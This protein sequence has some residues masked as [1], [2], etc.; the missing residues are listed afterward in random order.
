M[1]EVLG[2]IASGLQV[3]ALAGKIIS[4]GLKIRTL[5]H[6]I[7]DASE[8]V[9]LRLQELEALSETLQDSKLVSSK[10]RRFCERCISELY[11][12]LGDL[13]G[14]IQKSRGMKRMVASTKVILKKDTIR[15][16]ESRLDRSVQLLGLATQCLMEAKISLMLDKQDAIKTLFTAYVGQARVIEKS[17]STQP[18]ES[19]CVESRAIDDMR[20]LTRIQASCPKPCVDD[21]KVW[22]FERLSSETPVMSWT[23]GLSSIT[24]IVQLERFLARDTHY[25]STG[26]RDSTGRVA[27]TSRY[28]TRVQLALPHWLSYKVLELVASRAQLG[29]KQYLR[30]RSIFPEAEFS[31]ARGQ[32]AF[33]VA[34]RYV[35][36]GNLDRLT[37]LFESRELTPWDEDTGGETLLSFSVS[38]GRWDVC[39]FLLDVGAEP[40]LDESFK[41]GRLEEDDSL[42]VS[43]LS[44]YIGFFDEFCALRRFAWP[45][46][47]FYHPD[48]AVYRMQFAVYI[49]CALNNGW[50]APALI[51]SVLGLDNGIARDNLNFSVRTISGE[52]IF[53]GLA[54][55]IGLANARG[56]AGEWHRLIRDVVA[57]VVDDRDLHQYGPSVTLGFEEFPKVLEETTPLLSLILQGILAE[58]RH[59]RWPLRTRVPERPT[60]QPAVVLLGCEKL[61]FAWL[62]DFYEAGVDLLEYGRKEK[63]HFRDEEF[64]P[65]GPT[66]SYFSDLGR[67][68]EYT[69]GYHVRLINFQYGRL[70]RD[71]KFWWSEP[72]DEF[73]GD[74]W[75][76]VELE[77]EEVVMSIPGTWVD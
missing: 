55:K 5:C 39:N 29:W 51:R 24:G 40:Y 63:E 37:S 77:A 14:H 62:S 25:D 2:T 21:S 57:H 34:C 13:E 66:Y 60:G 22:D 44:S 71:W 26:K 52:T 19:I 73:A 48:F 7:Q 58:A 32:T 38:L 65:N 12:V 4:V 18:V 11:L 46:S 61:I 47:T 42:K 75:F 17:F 56:D 72:S 20:I 64:L 27:Q 53:H 33:S 41:D 16:L 68:P 3:A 28:T 59:R 15:K 9:T 31:K 30:V 49:A 1:A 74:F 35:R 6:E 36:N 67:S 69:I 8:E 70:P 43:L 45:D 23:I 10:A 50:A 76:L 54:W